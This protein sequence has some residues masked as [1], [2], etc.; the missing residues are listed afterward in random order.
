MNEP[1]ILLLVKHQQNRQLLAQA[2]KKYY[3]ILTPIQAE[4]FATVGAEL[5][6]ENFD[7]CFIDQFAIH[8]LRDKML[9]IRESVAPLFL[10][11]VFLTTLQDVGL[12]TDHLEPLIDSIV[13]LP[14]EK[15][16]LQ[17]RIRV[18]LRSRTDSLKL[19]AIQEKLN[20]TLAQEKEAN[21]IKSRFVSTVSHE[22]RNPLNSIS[23]MAQILETYGDRLTPEKEKKI[24][25]QLRRNVD[26]MTNLLNDV[27]IVSQKDL[28]K[29]QFNPAPLQLDLFCHG[30][31]SE[32]QTAFNRQTIDFKYQTELSKINL[33]SKLL[34]YILTNLL[35]NAYKYSASDSVV[36][37]TVSAENDSLNFTIRDRGIGIPPEDLPYLFD[38]FYRGSNSQA[39][40]GTGLGLAIAKDYTELHQG[41]ISVESELEKGTIFTVTIPI[42]KAE[43]SGSS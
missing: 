30:V 40:Q 9:E 31:I 41:T 43:A 21:Q 24:L 38:S 13:Y 5:L 1:K 42:T 12:S 18:L 26:K 3:Q 36:Y 4:D 33:D 11:F 25:Q 35:A 20:R 28:N 17:T 2:L 27:L 15:V 32:V 19:K 22:F 7:L 37:F 39:H 23:G 6:E 34:N 14:T 10:P 29:L 8:L 16:E